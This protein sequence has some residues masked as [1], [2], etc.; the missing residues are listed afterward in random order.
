MPLEGI[1]GTVLLLAVF[2]FALVGCRSPSPAAVG[3]AEAGFP[4]T[5]R[6]DLGREVVFQRA[7]RRL[8]SLAPAH[9]E[10]LVA[11]GLDAQLVAIDSYS[12]LPRGGAPVPRLNCWPQPPAE[13]IRA[14]SPDVVLVFAEGASVV[15]PLAAAGV[16]VLKLFP[17]TVD[18]TLQ[19]LRLLG[20]LLGVGERADRLARDIERRRDE[21]RGRLRGVRAPSVMFEMDGSDP[22]KPFVAG[23][24]GIYHELLELAG[25]R[26]VFADLPQGAAQ[27]S[28]ELVIARDPDVILMGD[29]ESPSAPQSPKLLRDRPGWGGLRAVAHGRVFPIDGTLITRAGPRMIEGAERVARLLHPDRFSSGQSRSGNA[30][31]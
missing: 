21:L 20:D 13:A 15:E 6:D 22:G 16:P 1:R 27:V 5:V 23:K 4:R 24:S 12:E 14:L 19:Q 8:I 2:A 10:T 7:P 3:A 31:R 17:E 26:N 25:G 28:A 9:T 29:T 11:L 30:F 18:A